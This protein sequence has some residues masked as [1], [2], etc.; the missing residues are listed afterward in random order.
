MPVQQQHVAE[1]EE[2][3][4]GLGPQRGRLARREA[5]VKR[6]SRAAQSRVGP[7]AGAGG[8]KSSVEFETAGKSLFNDASPG[9]RTVSSSQRSNRNR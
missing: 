5:R 7:R 2:R 1:R 3:K 6:L 4:L 9:G 8:K